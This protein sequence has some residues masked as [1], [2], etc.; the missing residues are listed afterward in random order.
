LFKNNLLFFNNYGINLINSSNN[1]IIGNNIS[2]SIINGIIF[3]DSPNNHVINNS[4]SYNGGISIEKNTTKN[5]QYF[6]TQLFH[7]NLIKNNITNSTGRKIYYYFNE[8]NFT[9]PLDAGQLILDRCSNIN[10]QNLNLSNVDNGIQLISSSNI[11]ISNCT[12][13]NNTKGIQ[14]SYSSNNTIFNCTISNNDYGGIILYDSPS[15]SIINNSFINDGVVL[16]GNFINQ[17]SESKLMSSLFNW[18]SQTI[19]NNN[20]N[21]NP[22]YYYTNKIDIIVPSDAGQIILINCSNFT[23]KDITISKVESGIQLKHS[24]NNTFLQ[25]KIYNCS[26]GLIIDF[27]SDSNLFYNNNF[28]NNGLNAF[29]SCNNSWDNNSIGNF[30]DDYSGIDYDSDGIGDISYSIPGG[31]NQDK[32]PL[33]FFI[34][35]VP[36]ANFTYTPVS[37]ISIDIIQFKDISIDDGNIT[38]WNWSFGDGNV[39]IHPEPL[40]QYDDDG[41]YIVNLTVT[42]EYNISNSTQKTILVENAAPVADFLYSPIEPISL[43]ITNFYDF[44]YDLDGNIVNWTWDFGDGNLSYEQNSTHQYSSVG[45]YTVS[46]MVIDDDGTNDSIYRNISVNP[47]ITNLSVEWNFVSLPFNKTLSKTEIIVRYHNTDYYWQQAVDNSTILGFIYGWNTTT[48]NYDTIDTLKPGQGYWMFSY[49]NCSL[50]TQDIETGPADD[51]ITD[52]EVEWNIVGL[53][54]YET[55]NKQNLTI[56]YNGTIYSW[57]N[58]TTSN[59]EE[60]EPLILSFVYGWN[61]TSQNYET[62]EALLPGKSYW[63]YA[64]YECTLKRDI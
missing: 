46:L 54:D 5:I 3:F 34:N 44:S 27:F 47:G 55:V 32:Y 41:I 1:K 22:L 29:D 20:I 48:Q 33:G 60:G 62:V 49:E 15:N 18:T 4:F 6:S 37:P 31:N 23:V 11:N 52:V 30:W 14:L 24:E 39:S 7:G 40:Y 21:G 56:L 53:T 64:Y 12:I 63:M 35:S 19:E 38:L 61:A 57:E 13:F 25:N 59:N 8:S 16:G 50:W 51:Y 58:A 43:D 26:I 36:I 17:L 10:I 42:D 9:I 2:T 28:S 45:N